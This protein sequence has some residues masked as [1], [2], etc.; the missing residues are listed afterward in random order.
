MKEKTYHT[1]NNNNCQD[2]DFIW[3]RRTAC[4]IDWC[5]IFVLLLEGGMVYAIDNAI[6]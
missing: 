4:C 3:I 2:F 5:V 6:E 1:A